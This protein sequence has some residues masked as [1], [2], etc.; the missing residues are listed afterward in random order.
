[1]KSWTQEEVDILKENY[2][3]VSNEKLCNLLPNKTFLAIYKKAYSLGFRKSPSV[4]FINRS[5]AHGGS[6]SP[7]WNGGVSISSKGYRLIKNPEHHR[8]DSRGY[9]LEHILIFEKECGIIIPNNCCVHH[10]NGIKNDNRIE[11][12]CMMT[13]SAHTIL[14]HT[15]AKRSEKTKQLIKEGKKKI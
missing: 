12:L 15:G 11:N 4:E 14:H 6:K 1:M 9:V 8:A 5:N 13:H 10:I 7:N 3:K 2:N